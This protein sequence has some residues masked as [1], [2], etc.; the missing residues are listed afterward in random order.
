M[1]LILNRYDRDEERCI[2]RLEIDG[3][4][5]CFTLED[6]DREI[7]GQPVEIWK[8]KGRTAI[9]RGR[10]GVVKDWSPRFQREMLHVQNVPGFEGIRIH[11]GNDADDVEGC[12]AVGKTRGEDC[13]YQSRTALAILE[14]EVFE[15][16]EHGEEVWLRVA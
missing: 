2:G 10:Y 5:V 9:P 1:E 8:Q 16:L 12:I 11:A 7:D 15:A 6:A 3:E 4:Q 13:I 14:R